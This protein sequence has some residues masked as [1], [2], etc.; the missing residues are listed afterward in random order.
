MEYPIKIFAG[1]REAIGSDCIS[2][3]LDDGVTAKEVKERLAKQYPQSSDLIR[4]S[5]I[6]VSQAFVRDEDRLALPPGGEF[7]LIP[8][9]SGG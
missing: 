5:R 1:I 9:V 2:V 8:P 4:L 3:Q 7:A 6:A